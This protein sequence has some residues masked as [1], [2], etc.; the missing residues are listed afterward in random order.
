MG[1]RIDWQKKGGKE[2]EGEGRG[3]EGR[4]GEGRGEGD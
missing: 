4:G 2:S 1:V 3:G